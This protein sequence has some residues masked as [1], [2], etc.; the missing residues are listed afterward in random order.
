MLC[1]VLRNGSRRDGRLGARHP[2]AARR[3]QTPEDPR[4][5]RTQVHRQILQV[6]L[7]SAYASSF[8]NRVTICLL[9]LCLYVCECLKG[10]FSKRLN[11]SNLGY[12]VNSTNGELDKFEVSLRIMRSRGGTPR[13]FFFNFQRAFVQ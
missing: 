7:P 2:A 5:Q 3:D 12:S 1:C 13:R 11:R 4:D 8:T 10:F 6:R 9:V